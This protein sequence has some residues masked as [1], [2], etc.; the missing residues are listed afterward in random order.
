[1]TGHGQIAKGEHMTKKKQEEEAQAQAAVQERSIYDAVLQVMEEA[2]W[3]AKTGKNSH[4]RYDYAS[5]VDII[6]VYRPA[7]VKAGIFIRPLTIEIIERVLAGK[8]H[9]IIAQLTYRIE[10]RTG[11]AGHIDVPVLTEGIDTQD[12]AAAKLYTQGLK[13]AMLQ[14]FCIPRGEDPDASYVEPHD[15]LPEF[16]EWAQKN[17][18]WKQVQA[19]AKENGLEDP[20]QWS[21]AWMNRYKEIQRG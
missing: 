12:K 13:I 1:M 20:S 3:V 17:G 7:M 4:M 19:F 14:T 6:S 21:L 15:P 9:R 8:N 2:A 18:G 5:E 11:V 16:R 10:G